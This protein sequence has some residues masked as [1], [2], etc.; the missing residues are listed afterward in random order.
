MLESFAS[1][2]VGLRRTDFVGDV[3]QDLDLSPPELDDVEELLRRYVE[4]LK[5]SV[6]RQGL[7]IDL[8]CFRAG[9]MCM[10]MYTSYIGLYMFVYL[11]IRFRIRF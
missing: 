6:P 8:R 4:V 9:C 5:T 2:L 10:Y 7:S 11:D 1:S 3:R